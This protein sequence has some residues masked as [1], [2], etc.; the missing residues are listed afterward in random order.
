MMVCF[1]YKGGCGVREC[2]HV[3]GFKRRAGLG[4]RSMIFGYQQFDL[5]EELVW[6]IDQ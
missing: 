3:W 4:Y 6:D 1:S 5:K 2:T